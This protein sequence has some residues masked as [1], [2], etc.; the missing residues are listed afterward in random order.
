MGKREGGR[1]GGREE[2]EGGGRRRR[3]AGL[4]G[5][6]GKGV[7]P[8][9]WQLRPSSCLSSV[10]PGVT[11]VFTWSTWDGVAAEL[12]PHDSATLAGL[13]GGFRQHPERFW[14]PRRQSPAKRGACI[15]H[16]R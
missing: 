7:R 3:V 15:I 5:K 16:S 14:R 2:G 11:V 4:A 1:E 8:L 10:P 13:R 12:Q 9:G 6:R